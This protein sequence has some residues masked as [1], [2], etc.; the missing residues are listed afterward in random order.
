MEQKQEDLSPEEK[1][2]DNAVERMDRLHD[3]L[4]SCVYDLHETLHSAFDEARLRNWTEIIDTAEKTLL[5]L[6]ASIEK[7]NKKLRKKYVEF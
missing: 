7:E 5:S 4:L 3:D 2:M 1:A 6:K